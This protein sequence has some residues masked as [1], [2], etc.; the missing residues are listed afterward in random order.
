MQDVH[1]VGL[2]KVVQALDR[3]PD[4]H[5]P[6]TNDQFVVVENVVGAVLVDDVQLPG[7]D[8]DVGGT[9]VEPQPHAGGFEVG[10]T[11][12]DDRQA[13]GR[14]PLSQEN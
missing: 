13:H 6:G 2:V 12:A 8:V 11:A 14:F 9:S 7:G 5:G 3:R 1:T 4:R 10:V